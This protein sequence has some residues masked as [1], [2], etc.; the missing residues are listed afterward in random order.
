[1]G[2][3]AARAP[4]APRR[5]AADGRLRRL[6]A[7]RAGGADASRARRRTTPHAARIGARVSRPESGSRAGGTSWGGAGADQPG[8]LYGA[9]Q[10]APAGADLS[11]ERRAAEGT[12]LPGAAAEGA[13][14]R[15]R[16]M[17]PARSGLSAAA[18]QPAI[19][20]AARRRMNPMLP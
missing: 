13:V 2:T 18:R 6:G 14:L 7:A 11:A 12:R 19:R 9:L 17:A 5:P 8:R 3:G 15:V 20:P 10:S 1:M 16:R 4:R